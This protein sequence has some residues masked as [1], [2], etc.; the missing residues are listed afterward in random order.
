MARYFRRGKSRVFFV[1]TITNQAA[2]TVAQ[3]N[4]GDD[5]S[6]EVNNISGFGFSTDRIE[7]P[8]LDSEYTPSIGGEQKASDSSLKIY[9]DSDTTTMR[10]L[11]AFGTEGFIVFS[12]YKPTGAFIATDIV[13]VYPV[14]IIGAPKERSLGNEA[15][16]FTAEFAITAVPSEDVAVVA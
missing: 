6:G 12:D 14:T 7:T 13:D 8:A 1:P 3:V 10:D 15:A 9:L 11:L 5:I 4:A 16:M 2:P